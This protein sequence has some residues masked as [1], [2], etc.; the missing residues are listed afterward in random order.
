MG[1]K[2]AV[3]VLC[4]CGDELTVDGEGNLKH[5]CLY[6]GG[7]M[8]DYCCGNEIPKTNLGHCP[9]NKPEVRR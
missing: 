7:Y 8:H 3:G 2:M 9:C 1:D 6:S 5:R 4:V